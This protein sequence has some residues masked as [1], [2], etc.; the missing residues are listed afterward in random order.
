MLLGLTVL[1]IPFSV[2]GYL[3]A[4]DL[5]V[6]FP[7]EPLVALAAAVFLWGVLVKGRWRELEG[8]VGRHPIVLLLL[9]ELVLA[10]CSMIAST[11]PL[12]SFKWM[13]VRG[14]YVLVF[15]LIPLFVFP[16]T[17]RLW[18][19]IRTHAWC[20]LPIVGWT[21]LAGWEEGFQRKAVGHA[22]FPFYQ[23]HTIY[24]AAL[25][26]VLFTFLAVF[27]QCKEHGRIRLFV[28]AVIVLLIVALFLS[29]SRGAWLSLV[30][31]LILFFLFR[32]RVAP[33]AWWCGA[34]GLVGCV[35]LF[36]APL[37]RSILANRSDA[38]RKGATWSDVL[39]SLTNVTTDTSNRERLNR[40]NCAQRMF[41]E[42]PILG[43]GPGTFKFSY[44]AYQVKAEMTA[45]S[46]PIRSVPR[47]VHRE[48]PVATL[49][50][51]PQELRDDPGTAHSEYLL[52]LSE[53]GLP[54][55]LAFAGLLLLVLNRTI[56]FCR[57]TDD[58]HARRTLVLVALP[59]LAYGVHGLF[60]NFLDDPK[61][62]LP[63]FLLLALFVK[64]EQHPQGD[65]TSFFGPGDPIAGPLT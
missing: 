1:S 45:I 42:R 46:A 60:N 9:A 26:F 59:L 36:R 48:G 38:D 17:D 53:R 51:A 12:V 24:A 14:A 39:L 32:L 8:R 22:S 6:V 2:K 50:K 10:G 28:A 62:A 27:H 23:D 29:L 61:I 65:L 33:W 3:P 55:L 7:A 5:E 13:L 16:G 40:W 4:L 31:A 49:R 58:A 57:R 21:L 43:H 41:R 19:W 52:A 15:F 34:L 54:G 37:E 11:L 64:E 44:P 63:F 35:L 56:V 30:A 47:S 25:V 18:T 20:F